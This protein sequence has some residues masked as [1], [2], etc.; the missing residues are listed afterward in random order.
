MSDSPPEIDLPTVDYGRDESVPPPTE[1]STVEPA[2]DVEMFGL[3]DVI[4]AFTALRHEY[5]GK[6]RESRVLFE[7]VTAS[8]ANIQQFEAQLAERLASAPT[9]AD[10]VRMVNVIIDMDLH[11]TRAVDSTKQFLAAEQLRRVEGMKSVLA[12]FDRV[13]RVSRWF[14]KR[15]I[16]ATRELIKAELEAVQ[17]PNV[18]SEGLSMVVSRLRRLMREQQIKRVETVGQPFNPESMNAVSAVDSNTVPAGHV[19]DE[20]SPA[21]FWRGRTMRFADVRVSKQRNQ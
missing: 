15:S 21:Y 20:L 4:E 5:R 2:A 6:T 19:V 9:D 16:P 17:K 11:L 18:A 14:A 1:F 7:L 3:V 10:A 12:S 8:A 13:N